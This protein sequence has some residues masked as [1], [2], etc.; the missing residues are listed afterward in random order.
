M[1]DEITKQNLDGARAELDKAAERHSDSLDRLSAVLEEHEESARGKEAKEEMKELMNTLGHVRVPMQYVR[2]QGYEVAAIS[3][4]EDAERIV[5]MARA[6][7]VKDR[8]TLASDLLPDLMAE[9]FIMGFSMGAESL[10]QSQ[11]EEE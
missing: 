9:A 6:G 10:W 5:K 3:C 7:S 11:N 1:P 2:D 4:H 8:L